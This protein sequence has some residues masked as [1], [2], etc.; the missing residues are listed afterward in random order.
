MES[1]SSSSSSSA[2]SP[3]PAPAPVAL[4]E[5][6]LRQLLQLVATKPPETIVLVLR[7]LPAVELARLTCVHKAYLVGW[8]SLRKL[9]PGRRYTQHSAKHLEWTALHCHSRLERAAAL[10]NVTVIRAMLAAGVDEHGAP[11]VEASDQMYD[12]L[13]DTAASCAAKGGHLLAVK[14]LWEAGADLNTMYDRSLRF[15][16]AE[17][18][19]DVVR[20]LI[21]QHSAS[22]NP[23]GDDGPM[24]EAS[25]HGHFD[26]VKLLIK[27]G[28][29]VD[30]YDDDLAL[31]KACNNGHADV[32]KLLIKH[33]AIGGPSNDA[34]L[35][36]ACISGSVDAVQLL[37]Q[38]GA[39]VHARDDH[40][41]IVASANG[42]VDLVQLLIQHGAKID[43][44][45]ARHLSPLHLA[46]R[47][48]RTTVVQLLLQ[49]GADV[50]ARN[51][52]VLRDASENG[53][54][55]VV[56]LL[57]QPP[58]SRANSHRARC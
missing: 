37:V 41:V 40:P 14:L 46:S 22:V 13:L 55:A 34:S 15:A 3:A 33:G 16:C 9:H 45:D 7:D 1:P 58:C 54:A 31:L 23:D 27:Q 4:S 57:I 26:V 11:L 53:H 36:L 18:H 32:V 28:A 17:G 52:E 12:R 29:N 21:E 47:H 5:D 6:E 49:H 2:A 20:Y 38:Q 50:H 19:A 48:G 8:R 51:D 44:I 10:G 56:Q 25:E 24:I 43:A 39:N 42:R 35:A 30:S